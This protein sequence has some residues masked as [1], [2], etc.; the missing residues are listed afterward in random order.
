MVTR[1]KYVDWVDRVLNAA[2]RL[3][4]EDP[5]TAMYGMQVLQLPRV[6]G[7][8]DVA[9]RPGFVERDGLW[10]AL[11]DALSDLEHLGLVK[12]LSQWTFK[13]AR[14]AQD[15]IDASIK[16]SWHRIF[17][18]A[19]PTDDEMELLRYAATE[20]VIEEGDWARTKWL[21][22]SEVLPALG[23]EFTM[24][25]AMLLTEGLDGLRCIRSSPTLGEVKF[26][27]T[28]IGIVRA[29][30][31]P[32]FVRKPVADGAA[33]CF[34]SYAH[35]DQVLAR[36]IAYGLQA[37]DLGVE[38]DEEMLAGGDSIINRVAEGTKQVEFVIALV[39][40][41]SV[42]SNWCKYELALAMTDEVTL[43]GTK[44]IP[45]KVDNVEMPALLRDKLYRSIDRDGVDGVVKKLV[46][47]IAKHRERRSSEDNM[48]SPTSRG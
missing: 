17:D 48:P 42:G 3:A 45:V 44:V 6:L 7:M 19:D 47:D 18:E 36:D 12:D 33:T 13:L 32:V 30:E 34:I 15:A 24:G 27:P 14:H 5:E 1:M 8:G 38:I 26:H 40:R 35:E 2:A 21:V 25:T 11:H 46:A 37:A 41:H 43:P 39:S 28:Y 4:A 16:P 23:R 10:E 20:G 31:S 22:A 29:T 9:E